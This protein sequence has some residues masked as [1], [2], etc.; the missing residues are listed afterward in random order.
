MAQ[1]SDEEFA[2]WRQHPVTEYV[3]S[4]MS[5]WAEQQKAEWAEL[6]WTG[7]EVDPLLLRE[8]RT[9]ADCYRELPNSSLEDWQA[10]EEKLNDPET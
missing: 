2:E 10:I 1:V 5:G 8:A 7:N 4:L 3:F 9:R 6:A